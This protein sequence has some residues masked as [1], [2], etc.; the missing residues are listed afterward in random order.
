[1]PSDNLLPPYQIFLRFMVLSFSFVGWYTAKAL[2]SSVVP[3][4]LAG[5]RR[6]NAGRSGW[7]LGRTCPWRTRAP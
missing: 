2:L 7:R 3:D 6:L 5:R 1:M 4:R